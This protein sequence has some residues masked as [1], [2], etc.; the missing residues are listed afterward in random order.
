MKFLFV[1]GDYDGD[2]VEVTYHQK[3]PDVLLLSKIRLPTIP[4]QATTEA[5]SRKNYSMISYKREELIDS[6][7]K[8][9]V[10]YFGGNPAQPIRMLVEG[11]ASLKAKLEE[12][13]ARAV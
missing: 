2:M 6:D 1:G 10:V 9:Y 3:R 8:T 11:Y 13:E 7:G 4:L 5:I 12:A